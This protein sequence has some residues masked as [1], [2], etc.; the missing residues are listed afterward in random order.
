M[1]FAGVD[2][3]HGSADILKDNF[4]DAYVNTLLTDKVVPLLGDCTWL[5]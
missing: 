5:C 2:Y 4:Y 1:Q 3:C